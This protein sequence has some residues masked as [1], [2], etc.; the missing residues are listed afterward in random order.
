[1]K[2]LDHLKAI[3]IGFIVFVATMAF[4]FPM[5]AVYR[6]AI[7]PGHPTQ[8]YIDAAQWI[9][10]WSSHLFGPLLFFALNYWMVKR[11]VEGNAKLFAGATILWYVIVDFGL[12][13]LAG[14]EILAMLTAPVLVSLAVK[15]AAAF[16]GAHLG[17]TKNPRLIPQS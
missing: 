4:S 9:A 16:Y 8:F 6:Y 13:S 11:R 2:A 15:T 17:S 10:P 12:A 14:Y 7:E 3:G 1:M 5:V